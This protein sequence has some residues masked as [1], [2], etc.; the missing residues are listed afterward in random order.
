MNPEALREVTDET[1][2]R[3][4]I[5]RGFGDLQAATARLADELSKQYSLGYSST[6]D[7][8]TAAGIQS[9]WKCA[10]GGSSSAPGAA[11]WPLRNVGPGPSRG[12][13]FRPA[14]TP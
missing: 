13:V 7:R 2:G 14:D 5:V 11:T 9:A 8:R 12:R 10:T 4:E 6:E 1:G 3:T